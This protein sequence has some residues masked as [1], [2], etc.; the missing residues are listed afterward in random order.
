MDYDGYDPIND[1]SVSIWLE[2]QI[3]RSGQEEQITILE[4]SIYYHDLIE[5]ANLFLLSRLDL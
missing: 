5:R 2:D 3:I 1:Y 4:S